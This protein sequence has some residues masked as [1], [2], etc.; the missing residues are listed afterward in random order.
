M[1]HVFEECPMSQAQQ[2]FSKPM[3]A[4]FLRPNNDPYVPTYNPGW[5]NHPNFLW[6][7]Q[8]NDYPW[9]NHASH[10][11]HS[12]TSS[13]HQPNFSNHHYNS[14]NHPPKISNY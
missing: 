14:L 3:N 11:H 5:R 7:Q 12:N 8:N 13:N 2:Y 10:F 4:A 1:N 6:S 9:S